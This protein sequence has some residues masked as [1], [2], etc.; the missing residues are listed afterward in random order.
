MTAKERL[1]ARLEGVADAQLDLLLGDAEGMLLACTGR[2]VL[3]DALVTAQVQLAAILYN[4]QGTEGET[5]HSEGGVSR[6]MDGSSVP[7][8]APGCVTGSRM[9]A[10][11]PSL[12]SSSASQLRV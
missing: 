3:P 1:A 9:P 7:R 6:A 10:G 4:R 8:T 2:S 5:A 11:M 12:P